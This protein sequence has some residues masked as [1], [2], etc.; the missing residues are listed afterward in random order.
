MSLC[1]VQRVLRSKSKKDLKSAAGDGEDC[2]WPRIGKLGIAAGKRIGLDPWQ[3]RRDF[4]MRA[5]E[6]TAPGQQRKLFSDCCLHNFVNKERTR[7]CVNFDLD[8][9][10]ALQK[11][12]H[13]KVRT[14]T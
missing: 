14:T 4:F 10:M 5:S 9:R 6:R 13:C 2:C 8:Y 1:A 7:P 11:L 3:A 12:F